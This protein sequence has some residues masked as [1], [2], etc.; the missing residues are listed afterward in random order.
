MEYQAMVKAVKSRVHRGYHTVVI[1]AFVVLLTTVLLTC[2]VF[3]SHGFAQQISKKDH[4]RYK[5][6]RTA[7]KQK[8][9]LMKKLF[10]EKG[11]P[12]PPDKIFIRVFKEE[13]ILGLWAFSDRDYRFHL[14]KRYPICLVPGRLGPK[15]QEGDMQVPEGFY[16]INRFNPASSFYLSLSINYPNASDRILGVRGNLGCDIFIHGS[17]ATIG[18]IP[19]TDTFI[20]ELYMV[21]VEAMESGQG[22]I[23]VH[24]FPAPLDEGGMA[25]LREEFSDSQYPWLISFWE[26]LK[27][28]YD[29]FEQNRKLP[30]IRVDNKGRY[31][32]STP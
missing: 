3:A 25:K 10:E 19:I 14:V 7:Y 8:E 30:S 32:I 22:K 26:N 11:L 27:I 5:R 13:K 20:K 23:P 12:Y 6:V 17:C 24:I 9:G 1:E 2:F 4:M 31:I 15:M 18:C 21:A 29:Y 16:H 28:G